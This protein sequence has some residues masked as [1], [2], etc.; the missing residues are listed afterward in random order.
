ML[1]AVAPTAPPPNIYVIETRLASGPILN[2]DAQT[3]APELLH[4]FRNQSDAAFT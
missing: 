2:P 1:N 3:G 4:E